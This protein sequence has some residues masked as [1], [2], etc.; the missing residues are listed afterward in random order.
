VPGPPGGNES[1]VISI[2]VPGPLTREDIKKLNDMIR[3][4]LG[5]FGKDATCSEQKIVG[6]KC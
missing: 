5:E 2:S 4:C 6:K 1:Y 3:N